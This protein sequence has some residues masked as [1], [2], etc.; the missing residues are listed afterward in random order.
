MNEAFYPRECSRSNNTAG[1]EPDTPSGL[2]HSLERAP[3]GSGPDRPWEQG[4][5][6]KKAQPQPASAAANGTG[7]DPD[8]TVFVTALRD[9]ADF[10][11]THPDLP[12]PSSAEVS[13]YLSGDDAWERAEVNRIGA[14]L[15]V[16]AA[17]AGDHYQVERRFGGQGM[18]AGITYRATAIPAAVMSEHAALM[19]YSGGVKP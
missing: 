9:L 13:P 15:G 10:I 19:S 8:R 17:L 4:S 6:A 14:V 1:Q 11:E 3:T 7:G 18:R 5:G 2:H 12:L 16:T